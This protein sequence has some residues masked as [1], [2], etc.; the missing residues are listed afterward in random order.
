MDRR[1]LR[2][3]PFYRAGRKSA[4]DNRA[5]AGLSYRAGSAGEADGRLTFDALADVLEWRR[6]LPLL[7]ERIDAVERGAK[8]LMADREKTVRLFQR[9]ADQRLTTETFLMQHDFNLDAVYLAG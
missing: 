9:A 1:A 3:I 2:S 7:K 4:G 5:N 8:V 6:Y